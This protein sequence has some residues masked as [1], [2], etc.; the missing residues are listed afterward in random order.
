MKSC[1]LINHDCF[2]VS[3]VAMQRGEQ[4]RSYRTK[5][6]DTL[7]ILYLEELSAEVS[8]DFIVFLGQLWGSC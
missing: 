8:G 1:S 4:L 7:E 6:G 3:V 5:S 2:Q